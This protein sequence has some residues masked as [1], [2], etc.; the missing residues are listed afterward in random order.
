MRPS[1]TTV[2]PA[3]ELASF[4]LSGDMT[5]MRDMDLRKGIVLTEFLNDSVRNRLYWTA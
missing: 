2:L 4:G 5:K 3:H 1:V